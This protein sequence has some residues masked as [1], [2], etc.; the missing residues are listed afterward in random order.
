MEDGT[1]E[2]ADYS[3]APERLDFRPI[4]AQKVEV[5][6]KETNPKT[7]FGKR[8]RTQLTARPPQNLVR[9]NR[10]WQAEQ[11]P[12]APEIS[13]QPTTQAE[14]VQEGSGAVA[15]NAEM[16]HVVTNTTPP[17]AGPQVPPAPSS[18]S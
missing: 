6:P 2:W 12:Q 17:E 14:R 15:V 7:V 9:Q 13:A 1:Y 3:G 4:F 8:P 10:P 5:D 18:E 11:P 16:D